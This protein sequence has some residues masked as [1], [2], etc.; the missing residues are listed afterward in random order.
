MKYKQALA[1][2]KWQCGRGNDSKIFHRG[3]QLN[4]THTEWRVPSWRKSL[5]RQRR[6]SNPPSLSLHL[7]L[8]LSLS[9]HIYMVV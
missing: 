9:L 2:G 1:V 8:S 7:S 6:I 4:R 3:L 5:D